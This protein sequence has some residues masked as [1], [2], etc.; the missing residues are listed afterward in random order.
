M[1]FSQGLGGEFF[2]ILLYEAEFGSLGKDV[3]SRR[4]SGAREGHRVLH[5]R[6]ARKFPLVK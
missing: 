3:F 6:L 4:K 5:R 2:A 1:Y